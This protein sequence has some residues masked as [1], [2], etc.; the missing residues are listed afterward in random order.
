M[1]EAVPLAAGRCSQSVVRHLVGLPL[2]SP[3]SRLQI[4]ADSMPRCPLMLLSKNRGQCL[5][6]QAPKSPQ[7]D[8]SCVSVCH[9]HA[10]NTGSEAVIACPDR[11]LWEQRSRNR[12]R[13]QSLRDFVDVL[14]LQAAP[15]EC[16]DYGIVVP[17]KEPATSDAAVC[18]SNKSAM[19][20]NLHKGDLIKRRVPLRPQ[21]KS[22]DE[23]HSL[24]PD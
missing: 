16:G 1:A 12:C 17:T 20:V 24:V 15:N 22:G 8:P 6:T 10:H 13:Y 19:S 18:P 2:H 23:F 7:E 3:S 11:H 14:D 21:R 9:L 4:P 5:N